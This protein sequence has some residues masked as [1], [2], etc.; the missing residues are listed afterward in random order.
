MI[1]IHSGKSVLTVT[2]YQT[3]NIIKL[4]IILLEY[5]IT[6]IIYNNFQ[7]F[8][9]IDNSTIHK[10]IFPPIGPQGAPLHVP[11]QLNPTTASGIGYSYQ[12]LIVCHPRTLY[13]FNQLTTCYRLPPAGHGL[14]H[15]PQHFT[16][17][18]I[19]ESTRSYRLPFATR[20][21]RSIRCS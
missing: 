2:V 4:H 11:T 15:S 3:L 14:H 19:S 20:G 10:K 17:E 13:F 5:N 16:S 1:H 8:Q 12:I 7:H 6:S 18:H 21:S 9:I